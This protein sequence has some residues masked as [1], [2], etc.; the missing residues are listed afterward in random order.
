MEVFRQVTANN[1]AMKSYPFWKELAMEAYLLENEEILKLDDQNF[2]DVSVLDAEIALKKG[3]KNGDGR[4]DILVKYSGE[5]LGIV[6]LKLNEINH[7]SLIQL[8]SYLEARLE[9]LKVSDYWSEESDPKWV[10]LLVGSSICP[11][12]QEQ[13]SNGYS[14]NGIPV[15]GM[16]IKRFRSET[17][18]IFIIS[19][20]FFKFNYSNKD[21]SIFIYNQKEYNKGRLVNSVI[22]SYVED[23]PQVTLPE[24]KKAF[25]DSI[26]GGFGVFDTFENAEDIFQRTGHKR[27]YI[28]PEETIQLSNYLISTCREWNPN[29]ISKFIEQCKFLGLDI[30]IK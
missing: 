5:Y 9:I 16:T 19:D 23:N 8:E 22:K 27:H 12:L 24:L 7:S 21:Y 6:E 26:Q 1:I 10:G 30:R 11:L 29:N 4:I 17:N 18:E 14:F 2:S 28:K 25:P 3:R 15:A 20:T 13:L